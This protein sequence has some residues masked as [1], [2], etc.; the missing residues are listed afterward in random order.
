MRLRFGDKLS[1]GAFARP[2]SRSSGLLERA[3]S[4]PFRSDAPG[5]MAHI[6]IPARLRGQTISLIFDT[7]GQNSLSIAAAQRLRV[8]SGGAVN[9]GGT[10]S[11]SQAATI[12]TVKAVKIGRAILNDQRFIIFPLSYQLQHPRR[13][14][15]V[16][17]ITGAELLADFR[18][19]IDYANRRLTLSPL[20]TRA[21]APGVTLP[22][23]SDGSHAYVRA[24]IDGAEGLFSLDSGDPGGITIFDSFARR[25]RLF[26]THGIRYLGLGIGGSD[27]EDAYRARTFEI[28]GVAMQNPIVHVARSASGDYASR[29]RQPRRRRPLTIH[30]NV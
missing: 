13:G 25:R 3:A 26:R 17:G 14:M 5:Y 20:A 16:S 30:I 19:G 10:G 1:P 9:V 21:K 15:T 29:S 2:A 7:G 22:F 24:S 23:F 27:T 12:A 6:V 8:R 28:A 18:I 11:A 4:V